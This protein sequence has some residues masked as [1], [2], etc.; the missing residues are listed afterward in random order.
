MA[1]SQFAFLRSSA[2]AMAWDLAKSPSI[3]HNI[4]I[5]GDV[6]VSNFG[7]FRTP[8]QD[9]VFDLND[10]DETLVGP[11][12]WDLKRLREYQRR[13]ARERRRCR[14]TGARGAFG[15]RGVSHDDGRPLADQP[16]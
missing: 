11:W 15:V 5:D 8:R 10:F 16:L 12:E 9:V 14:R 13:G 1:E 4:T 7:L 2:T 3:G 6:H